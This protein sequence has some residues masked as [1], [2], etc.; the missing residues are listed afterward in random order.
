MNVKE[1]ILLDLPMPILTERLALRPLQQGDGKAMFD[2]TEASRHHLSEWL[3]WPKHVK[4]WEDSE[5]YARESYCDFIKRKSLALGIFKG[6][7]FIGSCGFNYFLWHIPSAEI[8]YWCKVSAQGHG[9]MQEAVRALVDYG[10][11]TMG[12][13]RMVITCLDDNEKSAKLAEKIGFNLEVRALGLM[14]NHRGE[15]LAMARRYVK[16]SPPHA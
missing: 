6:D 11:E 8:G 16:F 7:E 13:K 10:F 14:A 1:P 3:S 9:Y 2:A 4:S 15:G 12:I 5:K